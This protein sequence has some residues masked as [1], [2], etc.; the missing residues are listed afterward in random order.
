MAS[1][2]SAAATTIVD[3]FSVRGSLPDN[4]ITRYQP[5]PEW[6]VVIYGAYIPT[7]RPLSL[8]SLKIMRKLTVV[9]GGVLVFSPFL[10]YSFFFSLPTLIGAATMPVDIN[11]ARWSSPRRSCQSLSSHLATTRNYTRDSWCFNFNKRT[12]GRRTVEIR[13]QRFYHTATGSYRDK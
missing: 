11:A 7:R 1:V 10:F 4:S 3:P 5:W 12:D 8:K 6:Q 2:A 9:S 13:F